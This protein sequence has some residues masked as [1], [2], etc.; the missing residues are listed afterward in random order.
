M[1]GFLG[2]AASESSFSNASDRAAGLLG[3]CVPQRGLA[4]RTAE[5]TLSAATGAFGGGVP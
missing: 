5:E 4:R 1:T 3:H 2:P